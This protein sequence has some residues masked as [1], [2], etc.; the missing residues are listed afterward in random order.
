MKRGLFSIFLLFSLVF[1]T[2]GQTVNVTASFDTSRIFIGDQ[3]NFTIRVDKPSDLKISMPF[4]KDT[5]CKNIEILSGPVIDSSKQNGR[6][7]IV[8]KYIVTS[9]DSGYYQLPPVY[10]ELQNKDGV[11]RY[12]SDYMRLEV[13]RINITP[14]DTTSKIYDIVKPY[15]APVTFDEILPWVLIIAL[16]CAIAWLTMKYIKNHKKIKVWN[17]P[18]INPDPAHIIAF[19]ELEK[20]RAEE[21]WQKGD[22][23][24]Y[25]TRLTEILRQYLEN[26]FGVFS[27]ELTTAETLQSLLKTGFKKDESYNQ[28]KTILTGAD[29]VKFAKHNP[30]A[31]ENEIHFQ[32]S[33]KF[34]DTTKIIEV[35]EVTVDNKDKEKEGAL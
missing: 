2:N 4:L 16:I 31:S 6:T 24:H 28:L 5:L 32:N 1:V 33:W 30:D 34:I 22:I 26:R 3:I 21:L 12:L 27:L 13:K 17:E 25:Y 11:K 23:K 35:K 15:K 29:L 9:F 7:S 10:V 19:R 18:V 14:A 20:L 8:E